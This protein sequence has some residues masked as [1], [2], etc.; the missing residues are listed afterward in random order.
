MGSACI[1]RPEDSYSTSASVRKVQTKVSNN[2]RVRQLLKKHKKRRCSNL[3][4]LYRVRQ[5]ESV[6]RFKIRGGVLYDNT[7][8]P[9]FIPMP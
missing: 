3:S 7:V 9:G 1:K 4:Q 2:K 6:P 5:S 8:I